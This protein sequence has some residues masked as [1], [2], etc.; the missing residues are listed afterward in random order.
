MDDFYSIYSHGFLRASASPI[1]IRLA[2]PAANADSVVLAMAEAAK[3]GAGLIAFPELCLSGYAI[4]DLLQQS[5]VLDAVLEGIERVRAA[6][7]QH[8]LVAVVGAPLRWGQALYNCAV[9]IHGGR[10]LGVVPKSYLPSYREFYERRWFTPGL[11]VEG[12]TIQLLGGT[13]PFGTDLVFAARD[14][15]GF[16]LGV[17]ICEDLWTPEP[18][19]GR[20]VMAGATVIANISASN[21]VIGKAETRRF[22]CR[23]QSARGICAYLYAASGWGES[24]TDLAWDGHA[25]IYENGVRLA[26][27]ERFARAPSL[28][29]ADIDLE[30]LVQERLRV[31]TF[32]EGA[33]R[34]GADRMRRVEFDFGP[35]GRGVALDRPIER[36]PYVPSDPARLYDDCFE[37]YNIQVQGLVTRLDA[38]RSKHLVIGVSGGLDSTQ[39]LLVA[40]R[41]FD[42]LGKPRSD[43]EAVTLPGFATGAQSK[44][45]AHKL[46]EAL[47]VSAHEVDIKPLAMQLLKDLDHPFARGE[48]VYDLTFENVQAGVRTDYLFRRAGQIGGFVVGTGDLSELGLG[49]STYGVGDHMSHY[50]VNASLPKTLIQHLIRW[51]AAEGLMGEAASPVLLDIVAAEISPELVPADDKGQTQSTEAKVGPYALQDFNLFYTTR[52]GYGP[53]KIAF[54]AQ[55]AWGDRDRGAWPAHYPEALRRAYDMTEIKRW[56]RVFYERFFT[57]SQY[58][59]SAVPNG[60]KIS[61]G[62]SLSPRGDWRAPSDGNSAAWLAALDELPE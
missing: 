48:K 15:P 10:V 52:F 61:S 46:M 3:A 62:G 12:Q 35:A 42:L 29:H 47:G 19:S 16:V 24:T 32:H 17:E 21:I 30:A 40:C 50:N 27:S 8:A 49:W 58:K 26:E 36:F 14:Y 9:V 5:V 57:T 13:A 33:A 28:L 11:G 60:P 39:A 38:T 25:L 23:A 53:A 4:D 2:D 45:Y 37:A 51:V 1:R 41:A 59:R 34:A 7:E 20:A 6:S 54:L 55:A 43:I 18:P 22:L 56:L 31:Q 44:G